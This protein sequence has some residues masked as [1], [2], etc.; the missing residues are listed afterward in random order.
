[1][2]HFLVSCCLVPWYSL[3]YFSIHPSI[4][5][6]KPHRVIFI[7]SS[8]TLDYIQLYSELITLNSFCRLWGEAGSFALW[9]IWTVSDMTSWEDNLCPRKGCFSPLNIRCLDTYTTDT[10][11]WSHKGPKASNTTDLKYVYY[12]HL[13][14]GITDEVWIVSKGERVCPGLPSLW[15]SNVLYSL[16][17]LYYL[18]YGM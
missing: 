15:E 16:P 18:L 3:W 6:E 11:M 2:S 9:F 13:K 1:M 10:H 7:L 8:Y 5:P 12:L 4:P 17:Q 14:T